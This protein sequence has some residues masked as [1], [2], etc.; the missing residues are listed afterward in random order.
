M[1]PKVSIIIPVYNVEPY[2]EECLKSVMRQ[3]YLGM[4]EC[5][6]ID[7]CGTDNSMEVAE[8]LI[9]D[10]NGPIDFKVLHHE[11]NLGPSAARNTGIDAACGDYIYFLDSDD[12]ISDDCIEKLTQPLGLEQYDFVIGHCEREGKDSLVTCSEGEYHKGVM[13]SDGRSRGKNKPIGRSGIAVAVWNRLFRKSF[14]IDN[15]LYFE[16]GKIFEDSIFSFD[17]ACIERKYYVVNAITYYYRKRENSIT[18]TTNHYAKIKGYVGL[19]QSFR[20]RVSQDKYKNLDRI[21]DYYLFWVKR[22]F[23]W[24]SRIEM[25]E[26]MLNY[27]QKETQGFLDVIPDIRYLSNKHD[28]LLYFFCRKD[29]TYSRFQYVLQQYTNKYA[30]RLSGRIMRN[31]LGVIPSK[32]VKTERTM[33]NTH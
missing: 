29:Q 9:E 16:V 15:Q 5:I 11:H 31:L 4:M 14:L 28:R 1:L 6:L 32:K 19:F 23:R 2:I 10:Y 13:K 21:Y 8:Q 17:L 3:T 20:D 22:V 7:D 30:N 33:H 12:W 18:T 26:T 24:I 25:D 27:V